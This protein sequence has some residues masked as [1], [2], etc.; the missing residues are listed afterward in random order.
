MDA[1]ELSPLPQARGAL[2]GFP[3][4]TTL[5]DE[6]A[7]VLLAPAAPAMHDPASPSPGSINAATSIAEETGGRLWFEPPR[8]GEEIAARATPSASM[9]AHPEAAQEE[10]QAVVLTPRSD[11]SALAAGLT[12]VCRRCFSANLLA[13]DHRGQPLDHHGQR[14]LLPH[15]LQVQ[16]TGGLRYRCLQCG[17]VWQPERS[18][19]GKIYQPHSTV[20]R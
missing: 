9:P 2:R 4:A 14:R 15:E 11:E 7:N 8:A 17:E 12:L 3:E 18:G 6:V 13:V 1:L 20:S 10:G 5:C 16:M 19:G